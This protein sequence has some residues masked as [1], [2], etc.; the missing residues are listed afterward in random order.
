M[1]NSYISCDCQRGCHLIVFPILHRSLAVNLDNQNGRQPACQELVLEAASF[2]FLAFLFISISTKCFLLY[3]KV[4]LRPIFTQL[5][6]Q[7]LESK[8]HHS[9][10]NAISVC[11]IVARPQLQQPWLCQWK[12]DNRRFA[13]KTMKWPIY[14]K[15]TNK[16]SHQEFFCSL[17]F[18]EII[19]C[20]FKWLNAIITVNPN[21]IFCLLICFCIWISEFMFMF[22]T[23]N[24][25]K[26]MR[27]DEITSKQIWVDLK[28]ELKKSGRL[29]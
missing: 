23:F 14:L 18:Q 5:K 16:K 21:Y 6:E 1:H 3:D 24:E 22:H 17:G 9:C 20:F 15:G 4:K 27:W 8:L 2:F 29:I 10:H 26:K 13:I 28:C 19:S 12:W 25:Q 11:I 7:L